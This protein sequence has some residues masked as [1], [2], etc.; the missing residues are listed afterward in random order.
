MR[1]WLLLKFVGHGRER[2]A[3]G[4]EFSPE[5]PPELF[6]CFVTVEH[7]GCYAVSGRNLQAPPEILGTRV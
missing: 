2:V 7:L 6:E 4:P 5:N 3:G 1:R